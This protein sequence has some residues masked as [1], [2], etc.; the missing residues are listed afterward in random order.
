VAEDEL[1]AAGWKRDPFGRYFARYH[2]GE[3]WTDQVASEAKVRSTDPI[4]RT[5]PAPTPRPPTPPVLQVQPDPPGPTGG[6]W[7]TWHV[8]VVAIVALLLGIGIGGAGKKSPSTVTAGSGVT[9][10]STASSGSSPGETTP[11]A[12]ASYKVGDTAKTGDFEVTVYAVKDPQPPA[13]QFDKPTTG[14]HYVSVDVQVANKGTQQQTFSSLV[15]F[16]LLD[17]ANRQYDEALASLKPGPPEGQIPAGGAVRGFAVF[18]IPDGTA[19]LRL[20]V[21]GNLTASGAFF[22][23]S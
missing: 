8:A 13:S 23:L 12:G 10:G 5:P 6:R 11:K 20:R 1:V 7:R 17:A 22:A 14:S 15:G 2:D 18:E 21:Q 4:G 16:H 9:D 19:G 3:Q